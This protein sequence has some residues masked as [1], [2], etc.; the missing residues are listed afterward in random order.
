M[1]TQ[2][3]TTVQF[4]VTKHSRWIQILLMGLNI[5]RVHDRYYYY[6]LIIVEKS[7]GF[8]P[9]DSIGLY[10]TMETVEAYGPG[11]NVWREYIL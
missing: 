11:E 7:Y 9:I 2:A 4:F 6:A 5:I 10:K 8:S 3:I 1:K